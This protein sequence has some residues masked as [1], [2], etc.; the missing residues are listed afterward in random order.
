MHIVVDAVIAMRME[1]KTETLSKFVLKFRC[2]AIK[3]RFRWLVQ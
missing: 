1:G 3:V 2:L